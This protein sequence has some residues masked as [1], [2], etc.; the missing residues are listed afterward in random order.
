MLHGAVKK[1]GKK[2]QDV[3]TVTIT[4]TIDYALI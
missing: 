2:I 3:V 1:L 4:V